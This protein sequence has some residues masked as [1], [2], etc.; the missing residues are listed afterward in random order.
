MVLTV[1]IITKMHH[2]TY[3][4]GSGQGVGDALASLFDASCSS[5]IKIAERRSPADFPL[6]TARPVGELVNLQIGLKILY[7]ELALR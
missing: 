6:I 1:L 4:F 5:H 7:C 2:T 3:M